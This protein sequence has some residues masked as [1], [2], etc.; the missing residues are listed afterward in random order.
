MFVSLIFACFSCLHLYTCLPRNNL[1]H[2]QARKERMKQ[3]Q[4]AHS[5]DHHQSLIIEGTSCKVR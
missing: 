4:R 2:Q 1:P 5:R 3:F